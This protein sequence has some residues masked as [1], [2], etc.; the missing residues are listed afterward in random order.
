[1]SIADL[2]PGQYRALAVVLALALA[3][4]LGGAIGW[5]VQT[6]RSE[7]QLS[8]QATAVAQDAERRAQAVLVYLN[9]AKTA[10][11]ALEARLKTNDE[12]HFKELS[13]VQQNQKVLLGR[14]A[15]AELRLSVVLAASSGGGGMPAPTSSS[16]VVHGARR[17]ELDPAYAQ[18]ILGI[19]DDGDQG[20]IALK[21][22]QAYAKQ[23]STPR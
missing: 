6:W 9:D 14:V 18:R 19:T 7:A 21:A 20:L 23:V 16:G 12:V 4:G 15:T 2:I 3:T 11:L 17:A 10:R 13:S 1:M 5:Q 22:C 8:K